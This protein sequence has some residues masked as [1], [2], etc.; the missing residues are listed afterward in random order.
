MQDLIELL[1]RQQ[2]QYVKL[3]FEILKIPGV[4]LIDKVVYC[5]L[6]NL[7]EDKGQ[8]WI[9]NR[10]LGREVGYIDGRTTMST[11]I[12]RLEERG[13]IWVY[14]DKQGKETQRIIGINYEMRAELLREKLR[15]EKVPESR[16]PTIRDPNFNP[17]KMSMGGTKYSKPPTVS[18][19]GGY[20]NENDPLRDSERPPTRS[21]KQV[22]LDSRSISRSKEYTHS[23]ESNSDL[24]TYPHIT[25]FEEIPPE[26]SNAGLIEVAGHRIPDP[27]QV[28]YRREQFPNITDNEWHL[29][30]GA[31]SRPMKKF[32]QVCLKTT[33]FQ[34]AWIQGLQAQMTEDWIAKI[35]LKCSMKVIEH[36]ARKKRVLPETMA[37][38]V[39]GWCY[40]ETLKEETEY[41]KNLRFKG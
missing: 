29:H 32:P 28:L 33:D 40:Q 3:Y 39:I 16:I 26:L 4:K 18:T 36:R 27:E 12:S 9:S 35:F 6:I 17:T 25:K 37:V 5:R 19:K 2:L 34:N 15:E 38:W 10:G 20:E 41:R 24:K 21:S 1:E 30:A 31:D 14:F 13:W 8:C 7:C 22:D 23:P 11:V